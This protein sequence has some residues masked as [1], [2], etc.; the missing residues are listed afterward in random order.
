MSSDG[1]W[2]VFAPTDAA[3][4][5]LPDGL[6]DDLLANTGSLTNILSHHVVSGIGLSTNLY[7]DYSG[8]AVPTLN[9]TEILV[10]IDGNAIMIDNAL[11]ITADLVADNGVVHVIDTVLLPESLCR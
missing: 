3:F 10:T 5:S 4:E 9:D 1:P 2:T 7:E 6:L 8:L 11:I